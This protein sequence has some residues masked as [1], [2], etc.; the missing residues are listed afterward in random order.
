MSLRITVTIPRSYLLDQLN[1][2]SP[3][4]VELYEESIAF[5]F[6]DRWD[7]SDL[8]FQYSDVATAHFFDCAPTDPS[9]AI[10]TDNDFSVALQAAVERY[11]FAKTGDPGTFLRAGSTA[12][13][14]L[15]TPLMTTQSPDETPLTSDAPI[16]EPLKEPPSA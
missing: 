10:P 13:D 8:Q 7:I 14:Y 2:G 4:D 9:E 11:K 12:L 15:F 16:E 5:T 6:T 1:V 3:H